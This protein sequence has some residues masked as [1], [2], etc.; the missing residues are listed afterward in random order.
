MGDE[1][2]EEDYAEEVRGRGERKKNSA[3]Y[4]ASL[5][6]LRLILRIV[7]GYKALLTCLNYG[8]GRKLDSSSLIYS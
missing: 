8:K 4:S 6:T 2:P 3:A 7:R 5:V 1:S